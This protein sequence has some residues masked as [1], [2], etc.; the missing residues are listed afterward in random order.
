VPDV[1][2]ELLDLAV[3]WLDVG[4]LLLLCGFM[5]VWFGLVSL[6]PHCV[7]DCSL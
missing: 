1:C 5:A 2:V 4:L 6:A 7:L 3:I